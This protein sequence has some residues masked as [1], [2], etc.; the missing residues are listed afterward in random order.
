MAVYRRRVQSTVR[1]Q[2]SK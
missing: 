2:C 1:R